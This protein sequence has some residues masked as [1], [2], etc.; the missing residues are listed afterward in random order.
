MISLCQGAN[1]LAIGI[2]TLPG[3]GLPQAYAQH[4]L[5][6]R[7][8]F[9]LCS[10]AALVHLST[11]QPLRLPQGR[12]IAAASLG[13]LRRCCWPWRRARRC[14]RPGG[15]PRPPCSAAAR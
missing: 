13:R 15:G 5:F 1:L 4:G 11:L 3:L 9:D 6:A 14:R 12:W 10:A 8:A 2:E 7:T